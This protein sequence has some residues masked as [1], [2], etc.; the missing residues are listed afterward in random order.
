M[1]TKLDRSN[2]E[3]LPFNR[4]SDPGK[5]SCGK[6]NPPNPDGYAT[7]YLWENVWSY[8]AWLD[9]LGRFV[10]SFDESGPEGIDTHPPGHLPPIPPM[11]CGDPAR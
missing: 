7:A 3:F 5:L 11:G 9:I 6:G 10:D 1:T 8:D 4:G 2:T